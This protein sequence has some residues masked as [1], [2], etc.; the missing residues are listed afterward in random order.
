MFRK[1]K[2]LALLA[3]LASTAAFG[4]GTA[5]G[6]QVQN[7][8]T[9][10]YK[11]GDQTKEVQTSATFTVDD[12]VDV[13]STTLD[14]RAVEVS[15]NT[16]NVVLTFKVKNNGNN[17][18]DFLL[19]ALANSSKAFVG[20]E[21]EVTDN[22]NAENVRVF[23]D[24]GDDQF[25]EADDTATYIDE[26]E[27]DKEVTVFI[28]ADVPSDAQDGDIAVYDLQV[29]V[30]EGG[31]K[32]TQGEAITSD[33]S[34]EADKINTVQ[35]VFGDGKGTI[36]ALHDGKY[37]STDAFKF[38]TAT[39]TL[40]KSSIVLEDPING[41]TNP[42]RIPGAVVRYCF[43]VENTG[44]QDATDV[45][46]TDDMDENIFDFTNSEVKLYQLTDN[47]CACDTMS[48]VDGANG[49]G[50]QNP[51]NDN[52]GVAKIGFDTLTANS[53]KCGYVT[54]EIK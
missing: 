29:Q 1:V 19:S 2:K 10:S 30:A 12:K 41:T 26:L 50:G 28:V 3:M 47:N 46:V 33:D 44:S 52:G 22:N 16:K 38:I 20:T 11:T 51:T 18:H 9:L 21:N 42:K 24:N 37:S 14:V 45:V 35:I 53:K 4:A 27:P 6:T 31:A 48:D 36:D 5:A 17:V 39:L 25:N 15:V 49:T 13:V 8:A 43:I 34:N 54:A 40:T 7:T 32:G 23:V